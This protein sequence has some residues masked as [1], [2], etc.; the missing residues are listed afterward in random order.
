[1]GGGVGGASAAIAAALVFSAVL[2]ATSGRLVADAVNVSYPVGDLVLLIFVAV[3]CSLF[4]WRPGREWLALGA[5]VTVTAVADMIFVYQVASGSYTAGTLLDVMWPASMCLFAVAAWMPV[6]KRRVA[7]RAAPHTILLTVLAAAGALALLVVATFTKITPVAVGLAA[8][9]L[10]LA[11]VRAALTYLENVSMLRSSAH[12]ALTDPLSGL[13]NRRAL[14][15]DLEEAFTGSLAGTPHTLVFFDLDGFKRYND[16]FGH[17]AGDALLARLGSSLNMAVAPRGRPYRLGGDEFCV[18]LEGRLG[19]GDRLIAAAA[20]ALVEHGSAFVI[21]VSLGVTVIPDEAPTASAALQLADERMYADKARSS[22]ASRAQARDVLMALLIERTP[23]LSV[24]VSGVTGLVNATA[25]S[26]GLDAEQLD[27]LLRAAELHDIGK[28]AIPDEILNKPG[29]LNP[30]EREFMRQHSVI[31]E[32]I[33]SAAPALAPV[34]RL[35]RSTHERWDG[36]GYP[37]G[38]AGTDIPLGSRI[39]AACDAFE[40]M[41]ADRCYQRARS[42]TEAVAELRRHAGTQ[43]DPDVVRALCASLATAAPVTFAPRLSAPR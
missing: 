27:E 12:D 32:R 25:A 36:N 20:A 39:L 22:R 17:A 26:F 11:T 8:G 43:F 4:G 5:G 37:D 23:E 14:M 31:G 41:T 16:S 28:L 30:D 18:L 10:I 21:G 34:A 33:L 6:T 29:A 3:A 1:V 35:V 42:E 15:H 19:P 38:L 13:G 24:H 40:A 2:A 9:A 7:P